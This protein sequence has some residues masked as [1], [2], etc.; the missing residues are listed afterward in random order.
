V[1]DLAG[2]QA[3]R[4]TPILNVSDIAESIEWFGRLGWSK[5]FDWRGEDGTVEFGGVASGPCETFL[6]RNGQG[7]RGDHAAWMSIGVDDVDAVKAICD[8]AGVEVVH[9]PSNQP[10][11]GREMLTRHPD[12]HTF[13]I[14]QALDQEH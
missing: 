14:S 1:E 4:V 8:R 2:T 6:C 7:G 12:G 5:T 10:W 3:Q 13:R 11:G 9:P